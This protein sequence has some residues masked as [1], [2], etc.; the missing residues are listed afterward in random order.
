MGDPG[1]RVEKPNGLALDQGGKVVERFKGNM[2]IALA[3]RWGT[4]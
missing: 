4:G 3:S 2:L 1:I